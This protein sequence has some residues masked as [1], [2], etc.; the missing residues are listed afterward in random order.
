VLLL[1]IIYCYDS[2]DTN[3]FFSFGASGVPKMYFAITPASF[4]KEETLLFVDN[5][6]A[7]STDLAL[8]SQS[9]FAYLY[10]CS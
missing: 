5:F 4:S 7:I 10:S 9:N 8:I 2:Q 3:Y 1:A 6:E